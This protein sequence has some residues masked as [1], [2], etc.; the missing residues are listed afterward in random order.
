MNHP[1]GTPKSKLKLTDYIF[2]FKKEFSLQA[3]G[4]IVYNTVVVFGA[5]F[6]GRTID[7]AGLINQTDSSVWTF[8]S[9]LFMFLG[10]TLIF[11]IARYF[12]RFY[13]RILVN[14]M[15]CDI[16][17][18]LLDNILS[19]PITALSSEKTGDIMS[20]IVGDVDAVCASV[21]TTVTE[22]W[23]TVLLMLSY[24][25][26]CLFFSPTLTLI[27]SVPIPFVLLLA[28]AIRSRLYNL[29]Q[30]SRKSAS[31]INVHLQ[32]NIN[33]AMLLRLFGLEQTD[34]ERFKIL[35][36][37]NF[38]W[39]VLSN[40]LQNGMG[41]INILISNIGVLV[42][43]GFGGRYVVN[44]VWTIGTFT[45]FL[46]MF[47]A[48]AA[49]ANVAAK[50]MNTWHSAKASWDRICEKLS[51]DYKTIRTDDLG[52][53]CIDYDGLK[54]RDLSFSY[55][56]SGDQIIK[57]ITFE[58]KNGEIVGI[59]G[60]VGSGKSALAAAISELYTKGRNQQI[61]YMDSTR[62]V[63]SDD[64][65]FNITLGREN[66]RIEE[67][68]LLAELSDDVAIFERGIFT[69]L[70]ERGLRVSG[71]QRQRI[72]LA[73]AWASDCRVVILD[74]PFSAIDV[75]MEHRI[76]KNLR[77][78]IGDKIILLFSHRLATFDKTDQVLLLKDGEVLEK[79]THNELI[80][81]N[82]IYKSIY[83]A[84]VFLGGG[85]HEK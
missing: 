22:L 1:F 35:L 57:N 14:K 60:P 74:D 73:R 69:R 81:K 59:T 20:R 15:S 27:A 70:M 26:A 36:K 48:M 43:I 25:I 50:V 37:E 8:Y 23:D 62:F 85:E 51:E 29:S 79:G 2:K 61:A 3:I 13:M 34:T 10:F 63:F 12:K 66:I 41:P 28:Q 30:N 77:E 68:I 78:N 5:I 75:A 11:Q 65:V 24:F 42:I 33:G 16:R 58:A 4:G 31:K 9:N 38:K 71:G 45:A 52:E 32:H 82:G 47:I 44:G 67:A 72:A 55:P 40:I 80:A 39:Q 53:V 54:V 19:M 56:L 83:A 49:R 17:A 21:Q 6:L 76:M 18:G 84:Q 7:A 46:A 64:V